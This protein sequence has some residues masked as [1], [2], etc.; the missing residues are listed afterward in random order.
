MS[1]NEVIVALKVAEKISRELDD[2][3]VGLWKLPWHIRHD[4]PSASD[5]QVLALASSV[6]ESLVSGGAALGDLDGETGSFE[7]WPS[8]LQVETAIEFW[9]RLGRDPNIGE[10]AWLARS[11]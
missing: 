2:D 7:P 10:V 3:Y 5:E 6:L 11:S 4:W 1:R 9:Q 8:H